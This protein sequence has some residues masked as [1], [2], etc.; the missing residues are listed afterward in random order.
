MTGKRKSKAA[1]VNYAAYIQDILRA[2]FEYCSKDV[3]Y[4]A[5][6]YCVIEDKD[7]AEIVIPFKGWDAQNQTLRDFDTHR[8]NLILKARQMGITWIALYYC[9]HDLIFNLGHTVVALSKT[10]DDAKELVRR[11]GVILDN[12]P[13]ILR[14]GGLTWN[15][16]ATSVQITDAGGKLVSTFKAFPASPSAGRSFTGNILLLDEWAFQQFAEEIWTSAY[17]TINR[18]TGGKVI[19]LSTIKKGTL[20]EQ[21]WVEDNAFHKIFLSVFSDPRRT[22]EWY[23]RTAKDLGVLVKQEYPRTAEEALANV[24]GSYFPEFDYSK[25]TCEPFR[26]PDDWTIYN[27]MDYGLDMF[28]HY[29]VAISNDNIAYVFHEIYES[30]LII[31]DAAAKVKLA[32]LHEKADGAAEPWYKPKLR[33]APPDL[34]NRS[35]ETGK[36]RALLFAECG[37]ELVKSNND[38]HAGWLAIKELLKERIA[39]NGESFTRLKVFR[40][41]TNLIRTL[42]QLLIDEKDPEDAAKEPHELTHAPD[43]LR[44]FAIYW[45]QPPQPKQPKKVKYRPDILEDYLNAS[46]EE[47]QIIIKRYGEPLL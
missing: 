30:G 9:T 46:E 45:T 20:F 31:S 19:G 8:L 10:E 39:P 44:Y 4:W 37:L 17:P 6:N 24:G 38:R 5:N 14:G 16:T 33:L 29:K 36:S 23:E 1:A 42:P 12:Q 26:I 27:T 34:W 40:T 35:Q 41:C 2:E 15:T 18:P 25:H 32:E 21:L 47:R 11:M 43:A 7:S 13:E 3:V 22:Q 28:A